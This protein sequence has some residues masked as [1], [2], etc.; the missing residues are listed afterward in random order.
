MHKPVAMALLIGSAAWTMSW[1]AN[2]GDW[3]GFS[4]G[5]GGGYGMANTR[6]DGSARVPDSGLDAKTDGLP[7]SG[8]LFTLSAGYDHRLSQSLVAG[9]FVDYDFS[10]IGAAST[11]E[12]GNQISAGGRLGYLISPST[13]FFSTFGYAHTDATN[14]SVGF[15]FGDT[16]DGKRSFDGYFVGGGAETL[17]GGGFSVKAEYRYTS[18]GSEGDK[19]AFSPDESISSSSKP[20]IQTARVS[21]N[22]RF[23]ADE[24]GQDSGSPPAIAITSDWTSPYIGLGGGAGTADTRVGSPDEVGSTDLGSDGGLLF[25]TAGY[26]YQLNS[27]FV[28]GAFGDASF[29]HFRYKSAFGVTS[30]PESMSETLDNNFRNLLMI[31]GR[32]GYLT[33]PGTLI[34]VSG[35]YAN[36]GLGDTRVSFNVSDAPGESVTLDGQRFSGG[37]VGG[38][39]EARITDA[40][41]LKAEYRYIDFGS[42]DMSMSAASI[43]DV[44]FAR[45]TFDPTMQIGML[46][47]NWRFGAHSEPA[48][49]LK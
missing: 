35:G 8:G 25:F 17:I 2:A 34:F 32:V 41:S 15:V 5:I 26:D 39:I 12:V 11:Y 28:V 14:P 45:T 47:I 20:A 3:N 6:I 27:R 16:G 40:L 22:Y 38:G 48:A 13:L 43:P 7:S 36:A 37:F 33:S 46:S 49:P 31:G 1:P 10:G 30:D 4:V 23:G 29:T 24:Q 19:L 42:E 21:L 18:F 9:A 44:I